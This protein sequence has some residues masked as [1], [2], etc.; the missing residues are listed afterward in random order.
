M[1]DLAGQKTLRSYWKSYYPGSHAIVFI[2]DASDAERIK[3]AANE[4]SHMLLDTNAQPVPILVLANKCDAS[5]C[6]NPDEI[7]ILLKLSEI[8]DRNWAIFKTSSFSGEGLKEAFEWLVQVTRS[9]EQDD[10]F[11]YTNFN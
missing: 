11:R 5:G 3:S 9:K 6:L 7:S 8:A 10:T 1:W 2:V 4:F